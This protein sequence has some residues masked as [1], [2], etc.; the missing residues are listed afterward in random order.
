M[1]IHLYTHTY[2]PPRPV[3]RVA[4]LWGTGVEGEDA[5]VF[6][7]LVLSWTRAVGRSM[8]GDISDS[9]SSYRGMDYGV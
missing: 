3:L 5:L 4:R 1:S 6:L 9:L 8:F 7:E 2:I